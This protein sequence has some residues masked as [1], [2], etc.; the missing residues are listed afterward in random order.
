MKEN[1]RRMKH[2][3]REDASL[4]QLRKAQSRRG[5]LED[6]SDWLDGR[7]IRTSCSACGAPVGKQQ[8]AARG[9]HTSFS[10]SSLLLL[11]V[12]SVAHRVL[13]PFTFDAQVSVEFACS[14]LSPPY[15][16]AAARLS[17][18]DVSSLVV[19]WCVPYPFEFTAMF[20]AS[21]CIFGIRRFTSAIVSSCVGH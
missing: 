5:L 9:S 18:E 19:V 3:V 16:I 2:Q 10:N 17:R 21:D 7:H 14:P 20:L 4:E 6:D 15:W 13:S 12:F 1:K 11:F 8:S